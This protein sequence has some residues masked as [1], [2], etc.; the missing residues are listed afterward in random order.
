ML[1][2]WLVVLL[3]QNGKAIDHQLKRHLESRGLPSTSRYITSETFIQ[4]VDHFSDTDNRTWKQHFLSNLYND[5]GYG[6][7][8]L[9]IGGESALLETELL[10]DGFQMM[11]WAKH[12][13]AAAYALEH[14]FYG[15]SHP[16][17]DLSQPNLHY[18]NIGQAL[19]DIAFFIEHINEKRKL[20]DSK[21][22]IF[23]GSYSGNLAAWFRQEY[24]DLVVGAVASSAPVQATLDFPGYLEVVERAF[25]KSCTETLTDKDAQHFSHSVLGSVVMSVQR[26]TPSHSRLKSGCLEIKKRLKEIKKQSQ[27]QWENI[28]NY[29]SGYND[30]VKQH[31]N[32]SHSRHRAWQWQLCTEFGF[33]Q[34]TS[35]VKKDSI[36][37]NISLPLSYYTD[38][39]VDV[40]GKNISESSMSSSIQ[41]TNQLYGGAKNFNVCHV[42]KRPNRQV[43]SLFIEGTSHCADTLWDT[44]DDPDVLKSARRKIKKEISKWI[45]WKKLTE[46]ETNNIII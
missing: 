6:I 39:C 10:D 21:W 5:K 40:F 27:Q 46:N 43:K 19:A 17:K 31:T 26:D 28:P 15:Q 14:R 9:R 12:F 36:F 30:Y 3:F 8:F 2:F 22:V 25:E 33:C 4:N 42:Y 23:G 13:G 1:I 37:N 35:Q 44:D 41:K 18:L 45:N 38:F 34:T 16:F 20:A 7:N 32:I 29:C 11:V 24:P